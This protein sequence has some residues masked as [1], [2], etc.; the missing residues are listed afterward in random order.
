MNR[1]KISKF[2]EKY[3]INHY[4]KEFKIDDK[5]K[6]IYVYYIDGTKYDYPLTS[7]S[8][9]NIKKMMHS[10]YNEWRDLVRRIYMF[11]PIKFLYLNIKLK[12]QKY[13]LEHENEFNNCSIKKI[14]LSD[15][16]SNK[17]I[18]LMKESKKYTHSYFNLSSVI[19]YKLS[20]MK[21]IHKIISVD[22]K[23]TTSKKKR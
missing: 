1:S 6:K 10:Q 22:K 19:K 21:K 18:S 7:Q 5:N 8:L 12:K 20:T 9:G 14:F 13:Y 3:I 16:L 23:S 15:N 2:D 11:N 4:I 17:E